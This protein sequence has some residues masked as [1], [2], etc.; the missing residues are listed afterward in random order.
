MFQQEILFEL[1][2]VRALKAHYITF[3]GALAITVLAT[4]SLWSGRSSEEVILATALLS[5]GFMSALIWPVMAAVL[6]SRMVDIE[7]AHRG[8]LFLVTSGCSVRSI[9]GAKALVGMILLALSIA[10]QAVFTFA[11]CIA[12]GATNIDG[13]RWVGFFILL[14]AITTV[15]F[16]FLMLAACAVESQIVVLLSGV[17]SAFVAVF[18]FLVST[19]IFYF[20]PWA[21]YSLILPV[22]QWET[23]IIPNHVNLPAIAGFILVSILIWV[24]CLN[25]LRIWR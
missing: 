19:P 9:I 24:V 10:L 16:L 5:S 23:T 25:K 12:L 4:F 15:F 22:R 21:Y 11:I 17:V 1:N 14:W 18:C 20:F 2:K 8:W 7:F 3:S 13:V 6:A